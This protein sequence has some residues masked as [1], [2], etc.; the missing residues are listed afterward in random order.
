MVWTR[1]ATFK[2][3]VTE[4]ADVIRESLVMDGFSKLGRVLERSSFWQPVR[5]S[6]TYCPQAALRLKAEACL[7]HGGRFILF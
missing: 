7:Q 5:N 2:A 6:M 1:S 4:D 3:G